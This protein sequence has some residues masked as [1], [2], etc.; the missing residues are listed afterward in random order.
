MRYPERRDKQSHCSPAPFGVSQ[1]RACRV[2]GQHRSTQRLPSA[3]RSDAEQV[4]RT[5]LRQIA[6]KHPRWGWRKAH[7]IVR[8]EGHRVNHKRAQWLWR[9]EGLKRPQ[10]TVKK[11]RVGPQHGDRLVTA[12][13][14]Q[15]SALDFQYDVTSDGRQLRFLNVID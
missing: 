2:D 7:A 5:R 4:L 1:R 6:A 11:R 9:D 13:P 15:V 12:H 8:A 10:R 14:D 3:V